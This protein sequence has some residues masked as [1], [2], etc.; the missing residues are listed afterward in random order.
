MLKHVIYMAMALFLAIPSLAQEAQKREWRTVWLTTNHCIDW[1]STRGTG[2]AVEAKQKKEMT[3]YLDGFVATNMNSVCF[4]ARP[5][6][7][8]FYRSS[9]EPWSVFL[10]G[11]RGLAPSYDPLAFVVEECHKRGLECN[12][13]INPYRFSTSGGGDCTTAFDKQVKADSLL[14]YQGDYVVYNP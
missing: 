7:D 10:T 5:K 14:I 6:A 9:Y 11:T 13:W 1:P 8:A 2:A 12:V 4:Q 3:D